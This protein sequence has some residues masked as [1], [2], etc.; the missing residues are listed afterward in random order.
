MSRR[1][2]L[3]GILQGEVSAYFIEQ[4]GINQEAVSETLYFSE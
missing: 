4:A 3:K 2:C 1:G